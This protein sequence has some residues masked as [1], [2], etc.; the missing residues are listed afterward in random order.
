MLGRALDIATGWYGRGAKT[1]LANQYL[2]PETTS[3]TT[4]GG[5]KGL[6]GG[7]GSGGTRQLLIDLLNNGAE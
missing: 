4:K 2:N 3:I 6:L 7:A 5:I 1:R